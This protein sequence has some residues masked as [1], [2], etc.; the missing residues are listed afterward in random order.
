M[1]VGIAV[2]A[3][4]AIAFLTSGLRERPVETITSQPLTRPPQPATA[5]TQQSANLPAERPATSLTPV[6]KPSEPPT[7]ALV[8]DP[9]AGTDT[10]QPAPVPGALLKPLA[11]DPDWD[12]FSFVP[13]TDSM[14]IVRHQSLVTV[15]FRALTDAPRFLFSW[16]KSDS[17][18]RLV[19]SPR[20]DRAVLFK[21]GP[22]VMFELPS[23]RR[24]AR[25]QGADAWGDAAAFS[26]DGRI[27]AVLAHPKNN[28]KSV[29]VLMDGSTG[30]Q[31]AR[32]EFDARSFTYLAL[33]PDGAQ[34]AL[35]PSPS[36]SE[37]TQRLTI[38]DTMSG[39][40]LKVFDPPK[41]FCAAWTPDGSL[42][43][44]SAFSNPNLSE[45]TFYDARSWTAV[46]KV[47][48]SCGGG[49][50]FS[51][52]SRTLA[53]RVGARNTIE[54]RAIRDGSLVAAI[55]RYAYDL[56]FSGDG[57][58]LAVLGDDFRK[59]PFDVFETT[60]WQKISSVPWKKR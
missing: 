25:Y 26:A 28:Q 4:T 39:S 13:G 21:F 59:D 8:A 48:G 29:V 32:H 15:P 1:A 10:P 36:D 9:P 19:I 43:A 44:V 56:Q 38:V 52:D 54:V 17:L 24:I 37:Q 22:P 2:V 55:D 30:R 47:R 31:I 20:G 57:K 7:P 18:N 46:S 11:E 27:V 33:R 51:P 60:T 14:A 58:H 3:V 16:N 6:E 41:A 49:L 53:L 12:E 45:V 40:V 23:G 34:F 42:F 50:A 5:P 35:Q